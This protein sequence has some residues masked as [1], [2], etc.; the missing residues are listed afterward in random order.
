[1][2]SGRRRVWRLGSRVR[3]KSHRGMRLGK[4]LVGEYAYGCL[5]LCGA[6]SLWFV[7]MFVRIAEVFG[8]QGT[9]G[10][11]AQDSRTTNIKVRFGRYGFN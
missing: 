4:T 1:M 6:A 10:R 3:G 5:A 9:V 11:K 8:R 2:P 7:C